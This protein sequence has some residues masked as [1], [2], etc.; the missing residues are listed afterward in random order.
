[1]YLDSKSIENCLQ[2]LNK[3]SPPKWGVMNSAQMLYHCNTFIDV[4]LGEKKISLFII[5][6]S[7]VN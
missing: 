4:S 3:S 7:K 1:M 6:I 2:K 5:K